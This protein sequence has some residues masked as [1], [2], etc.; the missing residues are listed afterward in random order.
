MKICCCGKIHQNIIYKCMTSISKNM[1]I[2][3]YVADVATE[4][5]NA[6]AQSKWSLV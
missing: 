1:Y 6:I 3:K 5:N 4:Y 2:D